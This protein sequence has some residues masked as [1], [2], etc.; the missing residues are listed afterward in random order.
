MVTP[1]TNHA[2]PCGQN[3]RARARIMLQ[4]RF[5]RSSVVSQSGRHGIIGRES[6]S[7]TDQDLHIAKAAER[8]EE[9]L[10]RLFI[11]FHLGSGSI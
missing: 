6:S 1:A 5:P 10:R 3:D 7:T 8:G 4:S 9:L 11:S 2:M